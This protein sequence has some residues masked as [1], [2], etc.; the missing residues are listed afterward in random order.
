MASDAIR[1]PTNA[2]I[3]CL[4]LC[5]KKAWAEDEFSLM[6]HDRFLSLGAVYW[7]FL[8][9]HILSQTHFDANSKGFV[10]ININV[11]LLIFLCALFV[12]FLVFF[13]QW[14]LELGNEKSILSSSR[15]QIEK[16]N[17]IFV[18][19]RT[20]EARSGVSSRRADRPTIERHRNK[21]WIIFGNTND[22]LMILCFLPR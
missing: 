4:L 22:T 2:V 19:H 15:A 8:S 10:S 21:E 7:F 5:N 1:F 3:S 12:S 17:S 6:I 20:E 18:S 9:P 13:Y 14:P 11:S 16:L